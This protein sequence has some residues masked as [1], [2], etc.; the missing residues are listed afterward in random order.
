MARADMLAVLLTTTAASTRE[1]PPF[2][3]T[4]REAEVLRL[5][6]GGATNAAIATTLNISVNTVNKHVASILAKTGAPNRTAAA[7]LRRDQP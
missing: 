5:V 3:L 7:A 1:A 4:T 6:A 2:G